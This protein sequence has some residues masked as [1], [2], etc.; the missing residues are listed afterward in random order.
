MSELAGSLLLRHGVV[1]PDQ[2]SA[3]HALRQKDGGSFG[4]ALVRIGAVDEEQLVEFYHR[5]LM[6]PRIADNKML[7]VS[8]KV[9]SLVPAD[10]AAEFRVLPVEVDNEGTIT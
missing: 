9:L 6:I 5:R 1:K 4:E 7:Q 3:A 8:P 10:M 2:I